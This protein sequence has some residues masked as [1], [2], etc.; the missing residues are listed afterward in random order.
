[1]I[2]Y[3]GDGFTCEGMSIV[4]VTYVQVVSLANLLWKLIIHTKCFFSLFHFT[5]SHCYLY[6]YAYMC[7]YI[8][9]ILQISMNVLIIL[10]ILMPTVLTMMVVS[11]VPAR[12]DTLG[13]V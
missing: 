1:M 8:I 2:G 5:N 7:T 9:M 6:F 11:H 10:V 13:M 12:E 4:S 3:T